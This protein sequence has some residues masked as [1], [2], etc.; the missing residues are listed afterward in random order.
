MKCILLSKGPVTT[1][2]T[3][4]NNFKKLR[5]VT[6]EEFTEPAYKLEQLGLG[7]LV[8]VKTGS[9]SRP[10]PVYIKNSPVEVEDILRVNPGLCSFREYNERFK[11][12]VPS[13]LSLRQ[14]AQLVTLG[15]VTEKQLK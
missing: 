3:L 11:M 7:S 10:S 9:N 12:R 2:Y 4:R 5:H 15:L 6:R 8:E 14:R 13:V 1:Q